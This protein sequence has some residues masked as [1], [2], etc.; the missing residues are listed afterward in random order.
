MYSDFGG[1]C[2]DGPGFDVL[3]N[4]LYYQQELPVITYRN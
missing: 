4:Y 3:N 2:F 1:M